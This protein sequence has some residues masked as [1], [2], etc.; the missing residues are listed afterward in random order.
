MNSRFIVTT[1]NTCMHP[2]HVHDRP[3]RPMSPDSRYSQPERPA[4]AIRKQCT[5]QIR[6]T[7][8]NHVIPSLSTKT[9]SNSTSSGTSD[10]R[11]QEV[12][13]RFR[14]FVEPAQTC[15]GHTRTSNPS[16]ACSLVLPKCES[17]PTTRLR[18]AACDQ[19]P[20]AYLSAYCHHRSSGQNI[21]FVRRGTSPRRHAPAAHASVD[22]RS[23]RPRN[24]RG[25]AVGSIRTDTTRDSRHHHVPSPW[26][27]YHRA[28]AVQRA[29]LGL[30]AVPA[31]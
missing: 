26:T 20:T 8:S 29:A 13:S 17:F 16:R 14:R 4:S 10:V 12:Q 21:A 3:I 22:S 1:S 5:C 24:T 15:A 27:T 23:P 25:V 19:Y 7:A 9:S 6:T 18:A 11:R 30:R 2:T 31:T 28:L